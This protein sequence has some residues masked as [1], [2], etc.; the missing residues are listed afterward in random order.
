MNYVKTDQEDLALT[1]TYL[2]FMQSSLQELQ[3]LSS[4]GG[5]NFILNGCVVNGA[6]VSAGNVV[7]NGELLEFK[8]G[9]ESAYFVIREVIETHQIQEGSHQVV[10]RYAE[11]GAGAGQ[12]EWA[13]LVRIKTNQELEADSSANTANIANI[14]KIKIPIG[15][16]D[17]SVASQINIAHGLVFSKIMK[18]TAT[19]IIDDDSPGYPLASDLAVASGAVQGS[20]DWDDVNIMLHR[21]DAGIYDS[22]DY[23]KAIYIRGHILIEYDNS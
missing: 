7:V 10:T 2:E 11:F 13:S 15:N 19:I 12:I 22:Q 3:N 20:V 14:K 16:W 6:A 17:M 9:N 18:V 8:A 5:D 1:G 23:D 21:N 4:I